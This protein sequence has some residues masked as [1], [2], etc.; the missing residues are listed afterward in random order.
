MIKTDLF[1]SSNSGF[2]SLLHVIFLAHIRKFRLVGNH[3]AFN[4]IL[5]PNRYPLPNLRMAYELLYGSQYFLIFDL[6]SVFHHISVAP[7]NI[8]KTIIKTPAEAFALTRT[9]LALSTSAQA[10]QRLV[11]T[12]TRDLSFVSAYV[13]EILVFSKSKEEQYEYLTILFYRS[14]DYGLTNNFKKYKFGCKEI[15][16]LGYI[17]IFKMGSSCSRNT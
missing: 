17:I 12:V 9:L 7:E 16:C 10:F 14:N 11:E 2:G 15:K 5:I 8:H 3:K 13:D 4:K 6:I 1:I